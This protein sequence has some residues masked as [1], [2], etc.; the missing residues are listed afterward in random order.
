MRIK[1]GA[2]PLRYV[3]TP[4]QQTSIQQPELAGGSCGPANAKECDPY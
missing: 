4:L 1:D 2:P 3:E